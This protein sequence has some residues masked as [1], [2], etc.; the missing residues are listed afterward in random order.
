MALDSMLEV[1]V[2]VCIRVGV[3]LL[4]GVAIVLVVV[5]CVGE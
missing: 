4:E 2:I 5:N 1:G 3:L